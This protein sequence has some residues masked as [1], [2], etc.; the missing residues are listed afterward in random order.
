MHITLDSRIPQTWATTFQLFRGCVALVGRDVDALVEHTLDS[1]A[2]RSAGYTISPT[3]SP[4]HITILTKDELRSL[5]L[6]PSSAQVLERMPSDETFERLRVH[7][8]RGQELRK[9]LGLPPKEFHITLSQSDAH[10]I[11]KGISSLLTPLPHDATPTLLDHLTYTLR[12]ERN[13]VQARCLALQL[14]MREPESSKGF[15]RLGDTAYETAEFKLAMLAYACALI[16]AETT[17]WGAVIADHEMVQ[18]R[19]ELSDVLL[20]PWSSELRS[21]ISEVQGFPVLRREPREQLFVPPHFD[22]TTASYKLPRFFRWLVPYYI[23]LMPT[24]RNASDIAVVG[25]SHL[26]I[27]HVL[28]LTEETPLKPEWFVGTPVKNTYLPIPNYHPPTVEQMDLIIRL[29]QDGDNIPMLIHCGGGKGRAG[30]VAACYLAAFGCGK[31]PSDRVLTQPTMAPS[32]AIDTLRNIRPGSMETKQ[33]EAFVG[34]RCSA[35]WKRQQVIPDLAPEPSPCPLEIEGVLDASSNLFV[36]VGLPGSDKSWVSQALLARNSDSWTWISQDDAGSRAACEDALSRI[37]KGRVV[38]DRCNTS[39]D[40]RRCWLALAAHWMKAPVCVWF[41]YDRDLC[42][43]RAQDRADHPTLPPG[44]RVRSA[45]EQMSKTFTRP[46]LDEGF[47]AIVI[48]RSFAAAEEFVARVSPPVTLFKFPLFLPTVSLN[49]PRTPAPVVI[50]E[51][52][53]GANMGFSLSADRTHILVQN[54]SHYVNTAS[55]EQF[56]KLGAWVDA[57]RADLYRVLDRDPRFAQRYVLFGEWLAATHSIAYTNLPDWFLAFDLYDRS[58]RSWVDRATL[59][60][61]LAGTEIR[62][63]PLLHEG[64]M[65]SEQKLR[66]MVRGR[67]QFT[68]GRM[69]GVY[70]KWEAN[71]RV[72]N[73]GK[74][75]RG[76]FLAGNE[77]WTRGIIKPN[78][79]AISEDSGSTPRGNLRQAFKCTIKHPLLSPST[80]PLLLKNSPGKTYHYIRC[81]MSGPTYPLFCMGNPLLD[82]QVFNGEE[83]LKKYDLKANDAILAE[84]KHAPLYEELVTKYKPTYVAGGAAQNAARGAAY[85]LPPNS[86]VYAGCVGNDDLAEQLKAANKREG[87]AQVYQVKEGEKTGACGVIITGHNRSLVT[88]LRAAEKFEKAHLSSPE[89]APLVDAAKVYYVEGFFLTH[90][91]ESALELSKKASEASKV[92]ALNLSAPFIPQFFGIQLQQIIPYC[93]I[94]IGNEAEAEAWASATGLPNK[95]PVSVA[96]ALATQPKAN[97][98]RPRL[99]IITHGAES[100]TLVTSDDKENP[101]IYPVHALKGEEIVDTNGAGD[102]FTGA[103]LGAFVQGKSLEECVEAGHK[104]G[105]MSVQL[106]GPQYKWPKVQIL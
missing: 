51:K 86:V 59:S 4:Y 27:R 92:F 8:H 50:T 48:V 44:G 70:V 62:M 78:V 106:V 57:H 21:S 95:D 87:L 1:P 9:Q 46:L 49:D 3:T 24:P 22:G 89:V 30:T 45:I 37:P 33:Q 66:D 64:P 82:I 72:L 65:V 75:V 74:V 100:T 81:I 94:I 47:S 34:K 93:D 32:Q 98:S 79:L 16:C 35:I 63:V 52:V 88:T 76:D 39:K 25:S 96:Q 99:V 67:S 10:D 6:R 84:E 60:G 26:G 58:T 13:Y 18:I 80:T 43:S 31:I 104:L 12:L 61:L 102:A 40:D 15:V 23:A 41:D 53:D 77:H 2:W 42:T 69:E 19:E 73:R 105:A 85:V 54:R 17:E 97:P 38:L 20:K 71:G 56:K 28:T 68:E 36:F 90:G 5:A 7:A 55:H 11:D 103:F 101:K 29:L 83:L 91:S 14:C